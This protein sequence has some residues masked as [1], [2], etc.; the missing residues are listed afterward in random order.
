MSQE[1][2]HGVDATESKAIK[3]CPLATQAYAAPKLV[4]LGQAYT[5]V[6]GTDLYKDFQESNRNFRD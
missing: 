6:Q 1:L 4:E 2:F 3:S 5:L